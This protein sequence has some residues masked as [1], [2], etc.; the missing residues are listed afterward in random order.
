MRRA[1]ILL[2]CLAAAIL[3]ACGTDPITAPETTAPDQPHLDVVSPDP[4]QCLGELVSI[5]KAD[6]TIVYECRGGQFGSGSGT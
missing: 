4:T 5:L 1:R 2:A 6:G 3:A